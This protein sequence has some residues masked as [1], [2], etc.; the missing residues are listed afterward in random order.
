MSR[1]KRGST[2]QAEGKLK[3]FIREEEREHDAGGGYVDTFTYKFTSH[4]S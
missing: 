2:M 1:G 4:K 3:W